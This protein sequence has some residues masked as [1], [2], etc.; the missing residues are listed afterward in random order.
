MQPLPGHLCLV[1][2]VSW[3]G[4]SRLGGRIMVGLLPSIDHLIRK[5]T[6]V[7]FRFPPRQ[8]SDLHYP[9]V[10]GKLMS[11]PHSCWHINASSAFPLAFRWGLSAAEAPHAVHV[12]HLLALITDKQPC[13]FGI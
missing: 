13:M 10:A 5:G 12:I 1:V 3:C 11:C 7:I 2:F 6:Q 4:P 8:P 9:V